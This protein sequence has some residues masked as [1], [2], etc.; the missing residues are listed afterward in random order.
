MHLALVSLPVVDVGA[1]AQFWS[2]LGLPVSVEGGAARV[3]VGRNVL[4]LRP[5]ATT[6]AGAHHLAITVPTG[7][8]GAAKAWVAQRVGLLDADGQDEFE[9]PSGWR[10]R[11]V[12]FGGP[13]RSV[14]ELIE[15]RDLVVE[16]GWSGLFGPDDLLA[17]SEVGIAVAD[18]PATV[19]RLT[20]AGLTPYANPPAPSFAAVGDAHGL[21]IL[22]TPG[23]AWLPTQDRHA[24]AVATRVEAEAAGAR[25]GRHGLGEGSE[26]L[27]RR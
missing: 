11:S 8:F 6:A 4:R 20:A 16:G 24:S 12:Y 19:A 10:S 15:R 13:E 17:L 9:G 3:Q 1:A 7:S 5:A 2:G 18:V 21:L 27:V 22:V 23:R 26:L 25:P 14:L